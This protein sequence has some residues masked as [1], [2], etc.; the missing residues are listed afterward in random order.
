MDYF[1]LGYTAKVAGTEMGVTEPQATFSACFGAA[2][3]PLHPTEYA[4]MLGQKIREHNVNVW[5]VNTGWTGGSYGTGQRIKLASTRAMIRA[6]LRGTFADVQFITHSV[7]GL[8]VP[9]TC[10]GVP[11]D[12]LDPRQTWADPLA[13][14]VKA[15]YLSELFTSK[16]QSFIKPAPDAR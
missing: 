3:M 13:Y 1:V 15:T 10:P 6:A 11:T 7:F 16:R 5:L 2:F 9:A 8:A 14:D 12:L 4:R